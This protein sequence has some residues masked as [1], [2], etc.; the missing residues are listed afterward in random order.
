[1]K[2][3]IVQVGDE[4]LRRKAK[5]LTKKD[6]ASPEI[7]SLIA[8]MKRVLSHEE[9]GVAIAAPQI[10]ASVRIFVV[11]KTVFKDEDATETEA[12][13]KK[14]V[15]DMVFI[16]PE[17]TRLSRKKLE[18]SEGCLSVRGKY[19]TV[20]RHEKAS[21]KAMNEKGEPFAYNGSGLLAHIFQHETD[22]LEGV[23]YIDKAIKLTNDGVQER[24]ALREEFPAGEKPHH[25]LH[26]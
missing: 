12:A 18:M 17:I 26:D 19:G 9:Y 8:K 10:G 13:K 6:I 15:H 25:H 7:K 5:I 2:D 23:L 3:P 22:H 14:A 24:D 1:M 20:M 16:N 21:I 11:S 4:V